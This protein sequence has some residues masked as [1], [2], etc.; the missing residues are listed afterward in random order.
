MV[1]ADANWRPWF[2]R[3][4]SSASV[5]DSESHLQCTSVAVRVTLWYSTCSI[6]ALGKGKL[7]EVVEDTF[8]AIVGCPFGKFDEAY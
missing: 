1:I 8:R 2:L 7:H 3:N 5:N 6:P 4:I